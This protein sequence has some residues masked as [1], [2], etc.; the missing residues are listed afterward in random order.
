MW[1]KTPALLL[2]AALCCGGLGLAAL[3]LAAGSLGIGGEGF[4]YRKLL[5]FLIG[6]E[7]CGAGIILWWRIRAIG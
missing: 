2:A 7:C 6:L 5:A 1:L 4:G 3:I